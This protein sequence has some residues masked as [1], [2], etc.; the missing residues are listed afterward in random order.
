MAHVGEE[1]ALRL[2]RSLGPLKRVLGPLKRSLGLPACALDLHVC[3][4]GLLE[5]VGTPGDYVITQ[6]T[7]NV[8]NGVPLSPSGHR[9]HG[10]VVALPRPHPKQTGRASSSL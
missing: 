5:R 9:S 7:L 6:R 8:T 3:A 2:A 4:L 10:A 1:L